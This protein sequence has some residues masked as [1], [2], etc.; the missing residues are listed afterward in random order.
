M[1][2]LLDLTNKTFGRLT[3]TG[4]AGKD[5]NQLPRWKCQCECG[6]ETIV[7]GQNLKQGYTKSCGC[8]RQQAPKE[9]SGAKNNLFKH[10]YSTT[11]IYK[12][13]NRLVNLYPNDICRDWLNFLG[14]ALSVGTS[15]PPGKRFYRLDKKRKYCPHNYCWES[16]PKQAHQRVRLANVKCNCE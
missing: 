10:G 12:A 1:P 9:R 7:Y 6:N 16:S 8:W 14:F 4:Y 3:V 2:A 5:K 13:W 15:I 11:P